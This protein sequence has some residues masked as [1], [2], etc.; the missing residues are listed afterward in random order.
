MKHAKVEKDDLEK[1]VELLQ[2]QHEKLKLMLNQK[3]FSRQKR[4]LTPQHLKILMIL[5]IAHIITVELKQEIS[6]NI[7]MADYLV[8][9]LVF[10]ISLFPIDVEYLL[11]N[12]TVLH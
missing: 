2:Q 5:Q 1:E 3:Q 6:L 7:F 11:K 10:G 12:C 9:C 8:H 4:N